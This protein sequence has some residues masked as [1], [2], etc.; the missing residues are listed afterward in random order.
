[1]RVLDQILARMLARD[2][3]QRF[4]T[5]SELIVALERSQ[6]A[7][8]MLSFADPVLALKD[9]W[10]QAQLAVDN[11][12]TMP[13]LNRLVVPNGKEPAERWIVRFRDRLGRVRRY[14]ATTE[15]ILRHGSAGRLPRNL[16]ARPGR[17]NAVF[18]SRS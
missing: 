13:D 15:Q 10:V 2:P 5:A 16:Q 3:R 6:L 17:R 9:P 11:R 1:P 4:Q 12:P 7:S 14:R 8:A 18:Q